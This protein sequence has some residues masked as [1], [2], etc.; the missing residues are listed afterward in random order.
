MGW[1]FYR[2]THYAKSGRVDRKAECDALINEAKSQSYDYKVLKSAMVGS[3]YYAAVESTNKKTGDVF[4][5]A[6][7]I[8]TSSYSRN[9]Y[10]FGYKE[11]CETDGPAESKCPKS[12]LDIL[13]P[14]NNEWALRWRED[15]LAFHK[16]KPLGKLP[17]G[18]IISYKRRDGTIRRLVKKPA[19]YQF[20]R[21]F[22]YCP[23]DGTYSSVKHIPLNYEVVEEV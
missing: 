15:C 14:T 10:N 12:I 3:T 23:D 1:T 18:T 5:N 7:V 11:I 6:Y 8:L 9:G 16:I 17:I 2:A 21:P 13:S 4:V 20:K 19:G 22:W